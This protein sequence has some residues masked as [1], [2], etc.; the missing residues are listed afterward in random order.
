[1][2]I[3]RPSRILRVRLG[4]HGNPSH[5]DNHTEDRRM[6]AQ[7]VIEEKEPREIHRI[8]PKGKR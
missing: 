1:L 8:R 7:S 4:F 2:K 3:H 6:I 5:I